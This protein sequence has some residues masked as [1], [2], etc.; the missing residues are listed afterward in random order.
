M[1]RGVFFAMLWFLTLVAAN[2]F[3][4]ARPSKERAGSTLRVLTYNIH[5]AN[6][7]S[8]KDFIDIDAIVKVI[9]AADA[10]IVGLQEVDKNTRRSGG[11]DQARLIAQKAGLNYHFYKAIDYEGG[12]YGLAILSK[13]RLKKV[14]ALSLPQVFSAE[15]R[16]LALAEIR[17]NGKKIV[18]ANTHLDA[19]KE[20][21]NRVAQMKHILDALGKERKPVVLLGDLNATA[22]SEPI[23]LL[24]KHFLRSC[25]GDCPGTIPEVRPRKTIDFIAVKNAGWELISH[26]V[27]A[28]TYAS[29]HRPVLV[30]FRQ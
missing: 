25:V 8:K 11:I 3:G 13:H 9:K 26:E 17:I 28:E 22:G 15:K 23:N 12:E 6:P 20:E 19:S 14:V 10:D 18:F 1:K 21:G 2:S 24:D 5:H 30:R 27:I 4:Q 7:P 16:I 29:D